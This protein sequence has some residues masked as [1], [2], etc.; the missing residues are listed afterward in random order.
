LENARGEF[1]SDEDGTDLAIGPQD[2]FDV[3]ERT[4]GHAGWTE[5]ED[6]HLAVEVR[7]EI[8]NGCKA[9]DIGA[10]LRDQEVASALV[11]IDNN[12]IHRRSIRA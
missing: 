4:V 8:G 3:S 12:Q 1:F 11:G 5:H 9:A 10:Q 6:N 2:L 7:H